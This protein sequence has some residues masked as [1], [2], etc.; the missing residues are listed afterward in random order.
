MGLPEGLGIMANSDHKEAALA[1]IEW[2]MKPENMIAI[3]SKMG[4][5]PTRAS[6]LDQEIKSNQMPGWAGVAGSGKAA[7]ATFPAGHSGV[8]FSV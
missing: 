5:M 7:E 1:F 3:Q 2:W 4:L 6:I 8:V